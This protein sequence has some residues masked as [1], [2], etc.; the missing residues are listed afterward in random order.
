MR[1]HPDKLSRQLK[2]S[3]AP[4]YVVS[5]DEPL[6]V[7]EA[8][9]AI[10]AQARAAGFTERELFNAEARF[11]W[12]QVLS[13]ANSLSLFSDKKILEL[14]IP[15]GK[16]G[17]EGGQFFQD[18]CANINADNL[19]LII[20]PKVDKSAQNSK[21]FKA[22]DQHGAI[23]Q[24]WPVGATQMPQWIKQRLERAGI[25]ANHQ[26]IEI[27]A[28][29]VEGNLLAAIQEIEKLKLL[30]PGG[31]IDSETMSTVVTDSARFNVFTMIDR[32]LD[33]DS[34]G[35]IRTLRGLRDEGSEPTAILWAL[36]RELRILIKASEQA[37][38]GES[39]DSAL[40]QLRV[41]DKHQPLVRKALRRTRPAQLA[42]LLRQ[43]GGVD[44]AVKGM[45]DASPWDDLTSMV[46]S[47]SG[48]NPL[49]PNNLRLAL[50]E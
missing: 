36:T 24:V 6:L 30:A 34:V 45:R 23:V 18:Y 29:R 38:R 47:M 17:R 10:R 1:L 33:G 40:R 43:A 31:E 12:Q 50:R 20:L 13:E 46:L 25:S 48:A 27:L 16:P 37:A 3:L 7:Q 4:I 44:R 49:H 19:L 35:A 8:A 2:Q 41:W 26:A 39:V 11:E 9:D 28:E 15:S 32:I 5:G 42:M 22:L 14:R 21:W